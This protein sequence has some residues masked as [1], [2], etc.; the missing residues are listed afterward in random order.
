MRFYTKIFQKILDIN[1]KDISYNKI[2]NDGL[3]NIKSLIYLK[4]LNLSATS[5]T[6]KG[7]EELKKHLKNCEIDT[8]VKSRACRKIFIITTHTQL[9]KSQESPNYI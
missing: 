1:L 7:V 6:Q 3:L 9:D 5:V 4:K 2:T 8:N